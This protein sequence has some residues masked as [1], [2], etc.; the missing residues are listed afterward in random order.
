MRCRRTDC[1]L[2]SLLRKGRPQRIPTL[3]QARGRL[4]RAEGAREMG[5]PEF[6][7]PVSDR[8]T[9]Y[10]FRATSIARLC[11]VRLTARCY[12]ADRDIEVPPLKDHRSRSGIWGGVYE[13]STPVLCGV[14]LCGGPLDFQT[15]SCSGP[16]H[17]IPVAGSFV[18]V[19]L[20]LGARTRCASIS[21]G[22]RPLFSHLLSVLP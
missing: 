13:E 12:C 20:G 18:E 9:S 2:S 19:F 8:V 11:L 15:A 7:D 16:R 14:R 4:S 17:A 5:H 21:S 1:F 3:R 22:A 10:Y 6:P